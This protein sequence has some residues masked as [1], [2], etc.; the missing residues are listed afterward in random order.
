MK[1]NVVSAPSWNHHR[2]GWSY[3][4]CLKEKFHD[5]KSDILFFEWV[6]GFF[7]DNKTIK[8]KW[9][10]IIHNVVDY[11]EEY[12]KRNDIKIICLRDLVKKK[13]FLDSLENCISLFTLSKNTS[14]FLKKNNIKSFSLTH[15][16]PFIFQWKEFKGRV[17]TVGQ[18]MR[19]INSILDLKTD[20]KKSILK[21]PWKEPY[22]NLDISNID[23][24][25]YQPFLKFDKLI[26]ESVV[27]LDLYDAAAC[28]TILEC[29]M[30]NT[31]ILVNRINAT[32]EYL[33]CDYPLLYDSIEQAGS[34]LNE[35]N[36]MKANIYLKNKEKCKFSINYFLNDIQKF[37]KR[38]LAFRYGL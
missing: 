17:I 35:K 14:L 13:E 1:F 27:F 28:N 32:E 33:G 7:T 21:V 6:D 20:Y 12:K 29:I 10:G 18:W 25:D 34:I 36:I 19:K 4:N 23:I 37:T 2:F 22:L 38:S 16:S 31:P 30:S 15:P 11:P 24:I 5:E 8:C 3:V 26:E 9:S